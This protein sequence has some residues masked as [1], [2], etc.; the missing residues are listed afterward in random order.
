M[1][2]V[3]ILVI[4]IILGNGQYLYLKDNIEILPVFVMN[5]LFDN[6]SRLKTWKNLW[7]I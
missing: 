2:S 4:L 3:Q 1:I 6:K 7:L 5:S